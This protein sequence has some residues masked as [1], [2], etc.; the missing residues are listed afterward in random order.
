MVCWMSTMHLVSVG[1][2]V[3]SEE[4]DEGVLS[5]VPALPNQ[6]QHRCQRAGLYQRS[7]RDIMLQNSLY[8]TVCSPSGL[9]HPL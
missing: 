7:Q 8:L 6:R 3:D 4:A 5:N 9:H 2:H 1:G